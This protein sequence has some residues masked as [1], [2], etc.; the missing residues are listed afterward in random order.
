MHTASRALPRVPGPLVSERPT[1]RLLVRI[2]KK[3][4]GS[5]VLSC[6]RADGSV[7]WQ[8]QEGRQGAFFPLHD[9]THYAVETVL[10]HRRGFFGLVAEGWDLT[11]FGS[12]WPRGPLPADMDPSEAIVGHMDFERHQGRYVTAAELTAAGAGRSV[13]ANLVRQL[14]DADLG[15]L[16]TRRA[17]L[18]ELWKALPTGETLELP[19]DVR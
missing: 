12:P 16:R 17:E 5:A 1:C 18:F 14:T 7:T 10:S 13:V 11:D 2:K 19:F 8:R 15:A 3:S 6:V 9:L 4:D